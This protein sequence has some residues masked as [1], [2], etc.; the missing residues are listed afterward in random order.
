MP[1]DRE[2][3]KPP[4]WLSTQGSPN[5]AHGAPAAA[6]QS[7]ARARAEQRAARGAAAHPATPKPAPTP[8]RSRRA[9]AR[10]GAGWLSD[11]ARVVLERRYL[12][13]DAAGHLTETPEQLF[14][15]VANNIAQ[16][17]AAFA[18]PALP[19]TSPR[20][21]RHSSTTS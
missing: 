3:P 17:E 16:A 4:S 20:S 12:A 11:N 1:D 21:T 5:A 19:K 7:A 8:A 14:R 18:P 2:R 15:R 9:P 10:N 6:R 13:K